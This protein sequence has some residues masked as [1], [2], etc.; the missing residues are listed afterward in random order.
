MDPTHDFWSVVILLGVVQGFFLA[1]NCFSISRR[2]QPAHTLLGWLLVSVCLTVVEVLLCYSDT[3]AS[4]PYLI[5]FS[6]PFNFVFPPLFY[7]YTVALA[8][9][10]F[11]WKASFNWAF[12]PALLHA[13]YL[14]P[15]VAQSNTWL[16]QT[17]EIAYRRATQT[18][19]V[20]RDLWWASSYKPF[21]QVFKYL[22]ASYQIGYLLLTLR[23]IS[24]L[25]QKD[26]AT[27]IS[28]EWVR[29]LCLSFLLVIVVYAVLTFYYQSDV[30]DVYIAT[31][32]SLVF[33]TMSFRLISQSKILARQAMNDGTATLPRV[34]YEKTAL[35][36]QTS[37]QTLNRLLNYMEREKPYRQN[38]LT[39]SVLASQ[40]A[41]APHHLSQVIN[42]YCSQNFFDFI[43]AYRVQEIQSKLVV[44]QYSH[45]K[46][47]EIAYESGF[48]SKSAF[49]AAFKKMTQQTP[50]QYRKT[51]VRG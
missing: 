46:I 24:Q 51:G 20:F 16:L 29:Q 47:E 48:N 10:N 8:R 11:R 41:T 23:L 26:E 21:Y 15:F 19:A 27:K 12:L 4:V 49:N 1:I 9:P 40:L 25:K 5:G 13:I 33:F 18:D 44:P 43:N 2:G 38:N 32:V 22:L 14:I 6:E 37:I 45:I 17:V 7:F 28:L 34:K 39:L 31:C 30:G 42:Q 35:D 3:I 50:S 36:E